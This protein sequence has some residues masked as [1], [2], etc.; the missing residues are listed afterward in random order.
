M[1]NKRRLR[2]LIKANLRLQNQHVLFLGL[3]FV[4]ESK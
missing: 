1:F 2:H 3:R 4:H